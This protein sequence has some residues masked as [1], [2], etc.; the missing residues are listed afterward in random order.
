MVG[1]FVTVSPGFTYKIQYAE[2]WYKLVHRH[3]DETPDDCL[4]NIAY[5][6]HALRSDF[7]NP[8][9]A[10]AKITDEKEW[11]YY[12]NLFRMHV[13][14]TLVNQALM[15]GKDYDKQDAYFFNYPWKYANLESLKK[16]E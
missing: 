1:L 13:N 14:L 10:L 11:A 2:Q 5:L 16:A 15:L 3:M 7:A 8:L 9:N 6:E 12:R 4:E